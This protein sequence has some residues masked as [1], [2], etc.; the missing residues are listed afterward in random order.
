MHPFVRQVALV[1]LRERIQDQ[2]DSVGIPECHRLASA[3][4]GSGSTLRAKSHAPLGLKPYGV[5]CSVGITFLLV[6]LFSAVEKG[7]SLSC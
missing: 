5:L 1:A 7:M 4:S 3:H 6:A 2:V